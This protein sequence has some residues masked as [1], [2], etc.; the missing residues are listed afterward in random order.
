MIQ[1][2]P[3]VMPTQ[4]PLD[5]AR[6]LLHRADVVTPSRSVLRLEDKLRRGEAST[7]QIALLVQASPALAAR[8][9]RMAN[10]TFYAPT[11]PVMSLTRAVPMLGYTVLRQLV[12]ATLVLSRHAVT[13]SPAMQLAAARLTGNAVRSAVVARA[14]ARRCGAGDPDEG[15]AAGLLHDLGHVYLLDDV[16][17]DYAHYLLDENP[18]DPYGREVQLGGT[19]HEIVGSVF[20]DDWNLPGA[21]GTVLRDHHHPEPRSLAAVVFAADALIAEEYDPMREHVDAH[22]AESDRSLAAIGLD[23]ADWV[24][25][26]SHVRDDYAELLTAFERVGA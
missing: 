2:R 10:S 17:E 23:R 13:R 8:V 7:R 11:E 9:L 18:R 24:E 4:S 26:A 6:D 25:M 22:V 5:R 21:L 14:L 20:A 12:L 16:G 3:T 15:F 19:G 1:T